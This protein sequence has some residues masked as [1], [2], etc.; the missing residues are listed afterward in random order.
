MKQII[1]CLSDTEYAEIKATPEKYKTLAH[2]ILERGISL[3]PHGRLID[4]DVVMT[5]IDAEAWSFCDYLIR[6][7]RYDE[8]K[9]VSHFSD[10]LRDR[11][12]EDAPTIIEADKENTDA[13]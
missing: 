9:P 1:V 4:A 6:E 11:I 10:N 2:K 13:Q 7:G 5:M 8:Q 3:P 12:S